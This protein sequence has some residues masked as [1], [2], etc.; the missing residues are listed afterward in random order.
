MQPPT[1]P[2]PRRI[3][4]GGGALIAWLAVTITW[5]ALMFAPLPL[6]EPALARVREVCFG[7]LPNGLPDER[8]WLLLVLGPLSMLSFLWVGWADEIR[9]DVLAWWSAL[10]SRLAMLAVVLGIGAGIAAVGNRIALA[11]AAELAAELTAGAGFPAD[12]PRLERTAP[13]FSLLDQHGVH[14]DASVFVGE[15]AL[16]TFAY[17][18]CSTVCPVIVQTVRSSWDALRL[19]GIPAR[20]VIVTLDPWRDTPSS[21]PSLAA[22]WKLAAA[23]GVHV[24]SG[25]VDAVLDMLA[26]Y[27]VPFQRDET[28]GE[29]THPALV[30]VT[31]G[32]G[33]IAYAFNNPQPET[34]VQAVQ[35]LR[36]VPPQS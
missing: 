23:D 14:I 7:A 34:L 17:A 1:S 21:L 27:E 20:L 36:A 24:L 15:P 13:E 9:N 22:T 33:K 25:E 19:S 10:P 12:Y 16:V 11:K 29:V 18:H 26:A 35:R 32:T 28:S 6:P 8:G 30:Y 3:H 4:F 5:W 2:H 31:D